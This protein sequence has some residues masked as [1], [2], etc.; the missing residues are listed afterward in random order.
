MCGL[1]RTLSGMTGPSARLR[2]I[3]LER[4]IAELLDADAIRHEDT[5]VNRHAINDAIG[6][7]SSCTPSTVQC[8][9][10]SSVIPRNVYGVL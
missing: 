2:A 1:S 8:Q 7:R 4:R 10:T 9:G 6:H 5:L 3:V